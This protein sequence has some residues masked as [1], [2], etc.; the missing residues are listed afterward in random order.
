MR[1]IQGKK[2][3]H[4]H[5]K[6]DIPLSVENYFTMV[7]LLVVIAI[8][9]ILAALLFPVINNALEKG[10]ETSCSSNLKQMGYMAISY[11]Y[12]YASYFP[13][14]VQ[15]SKEYQY[16]RYLLAYSG[17]SQLDTIPA[18]YDY[19]WLPSIMI[20]P[21]QTSLQGGYAGLYS[22]NKNKIAIPVF[23]IKTIQILQP[24]Y[25]TYRAPNFILMAD[26]SFKPQAT[27]RSNA[28]LLCAWGGAGKYFTF[29]HRKKGNA[30]FMDGHASGLDLS[31]RYVFNK[32][33][34]WPVY[35]GAG[36]LKATPIYN[37]RLADGT[38]FNSPP[39]TLQ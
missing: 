16:W 37:Y 20:C 29:V 26:S 19:S 31:A 6:R 32:Q 25:T 12:D 17:G 28:H 13:P 11:G 27:D 23:K 30:I 9:V 22:A 24:P 33:Y 15:N 8:I 2:L 3:I 21:S 39:W 35:N 36:E 10:K 4:R 38:T 7:E 34:A 14:N 5:R 1:N 18:G